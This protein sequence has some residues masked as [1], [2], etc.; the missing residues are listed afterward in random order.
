MAQEEKKQE[1][2]EDKFLNPDQFN[3]FMEKLKVKF[4]QIGWKLR[5]FRMAN[6]CK[7]LPPKE[8]WWRKDAGRFGFPCVAFKFDRRHIMRIYPRTDTKVERLFDFLNGMF[9]TKDRRE[10]QICYESYCKNTKWEYCGKCFYH[11]CV[12]KCKSELQRMHD[13]QGRELIICPHCRRPLSLLP[14]NF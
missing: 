12:A 1:E 9:I 11:F 3:D 13:E 8:L 6:S 10:C 5:P 4:Q 14:V 7:K 2:Q